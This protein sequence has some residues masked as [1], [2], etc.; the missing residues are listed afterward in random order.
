MNQLQL[1]LL[2]R[3]P[4]AKLYSHSGPDGLWPRQSATSPLVRTVPPPHSGMTEVQSR[5]HTTASDR[6]SE[7][8]QFGSFPAMTMMVTRTENGT[9]QIHSWDQNCNKNGKFYRSCYPQNRLLIVIVWIFFFFFYFLY[10]I[11]VYSDLS[12]GHQWKPFG[13]SGKQWYS[14]ANQVARFE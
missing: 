5:P 12:I 2:N 4:S 11:L 8:L 1:R 14:S 10:F 9:T 13:W 3:T 6:L 7:A